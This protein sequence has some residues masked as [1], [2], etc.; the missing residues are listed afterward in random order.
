M[1][2]RIT[3]L[4]VLPNPLIFRETT[5]IGIDHYIGSKPTNIEVLLGCR[6]S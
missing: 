1:Q 6:F 2:D 4:T 3:D 5:V